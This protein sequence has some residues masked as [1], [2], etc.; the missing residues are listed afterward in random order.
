MAEFDG[1][2][3]LAVKQ[4][5]LAARQ[6]RH[7]ERRWPSKGGHSREWTMTSRA[8]ELVALMRDLR[9]SSTELER[10]RRVAASMAMPGGGMQDPEEPSC[11]DALLSRA[12]ELVPIA[13]AD[14]SWR[15][16]GKTWIQARDFLRDAMETDGKKWHADTLR[17]SPKYLVALAQWCYEENASATGVER[18]FGAV[19]MALR[20]NSITVPPLFYVSVIKG[21]SRRLRGRPVV[22]RRGLAFDE[23]AMIAGEKGWG[24]AKAPLGDL[25]VAVAMAL[26]FACLLRFSSL[27][28]V[29][30]GGIYWVPPYTEAGVEKL[31]GCVII[32]P[33]GK[34]DQL[35]HS[36][37]VAVAET[38][39]PFSLVSQIRRLCGALGVPIPAGHEGFVDSKSFLFRDM[40]L[41]SKYSH[42]TRREYKVD[43][44]GRRPMASGGSAYHHYL[45]RIRQALGECCGYS[46]IQ[47]KEFGTQSMRS[48]GDTH[49]FNMGVPASVR[50][51]LGHW[52]TPSVERGYLRIQVQQ[53]VKFMESVG[54]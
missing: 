5:P 28:V 49:L 37:Q 17:A 13:R 34:T 22:K 3:G 36:T 24:G 42:K 54:L 50:M 41:A 23:A 20:V 39:R 4:E 11:V 19:S 52:K 43:M 21:A 6:F 33:R 7:A 12:Q 31:G 14:T 27:A 51:D 38:G 2:Y 9:I 47:V 26:G 30:I 48:G 46:K 53:R 32:L 44:V 45:A 18:M 10:S 1:H 16:W 29:V 8:S 25:M 15:S 40:T 35:G